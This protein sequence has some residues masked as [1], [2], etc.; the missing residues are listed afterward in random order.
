MHYSTMAKCIIFCP[1]KCILINRVLHPEESPLRD[2]TVRGSETVAS[3]AVAL[4]VTSKLLLSFN[5]NR[6]AIQT[7]LLIEDRAIILN[8][9]LL[10]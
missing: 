8:K 6:T 2:S 4:C 3:S 9:E 1:L 10:S 7:D 5:W